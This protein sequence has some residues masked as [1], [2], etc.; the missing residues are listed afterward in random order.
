MTQAWAEYQL[1]TM[2]S[3]LKTLEQL[4]AMQEG[5]EQAELFTGDDVRSLERRNAFDHES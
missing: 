4:H 1:D 5:A 3:V 2:E